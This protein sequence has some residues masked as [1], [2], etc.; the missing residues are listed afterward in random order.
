MGGFGLLASEDCNKPFVAIILGLKP[1]WDTLCYLFL[2]KNHLFLFFHW[3]IMLQFPK[4]RLSNLGAVE[5]VYKRLWCLTLEWMT[6]GS[7]FSYQLLNPWHWTFVAVFIVKSWHPGK[8][9][10]SI[11]LGLAWFIVLSECVGQHKHMLLGR[12]WLQMEE[13]LSLI[14]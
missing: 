7:C 9:S 11:L 8:P 4:F 10:Y 5:T 1:M 2:F 3:I 13:A 6:A 14:F 12:L